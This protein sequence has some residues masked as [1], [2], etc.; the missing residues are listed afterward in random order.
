MILTSSFHHLSGR[1]RPLTSLTLLP[2]LFSSVTTISSP[3]V[4]IFIRGS[5]VSLHLVS[6]RDSGANRTPCDDPAEPP[7]FGFARA[8]RRPQ[9]S[10]PGSENG[11]ISK[12]IFSFR[13]QLSATLTSPDRTTDIRPSFR[14]DYFNI[15]RN[16]KI[17]LS[18][19]TVP[20][21]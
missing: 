9:T 21:M 7:S 20:K 12:N 19:C 8:P 3:R 14:F 17:F 15:P 5:I 6:G 13:L 11:S 18:M 4:L 1:R 10:A 2:L 16:L